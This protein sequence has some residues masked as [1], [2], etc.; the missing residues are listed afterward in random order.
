MGRR[1]LTSLWLGLFLAG[2][3]AALAGPWLRSEMRHVCDCNSFF[4]V[5]LH[6]HAAPKPAK[7]QAHCHSSGEQEG[8]SLDGCGGDDEQVIASWVYVLPQPPAHPQPM[9][10]A[11]VTPA[12]EPRLA[13]HFAE[14]DPPPPRT[15]LT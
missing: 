1:L 9:A 4:C 2:H 8:V 13:L 7:P 6:H 12:F 3:A 15:L 5:R 10:A 14:I 11:A